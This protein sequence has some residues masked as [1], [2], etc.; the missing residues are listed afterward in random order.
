MNPV[1]LYIILDYIT[2]SHIIKDLPFGQR[3]LNTSDG[4]MIDTPNIIRSMAPQAIIDQ[5]KQYCEELDIEP[6]G[7]FLI[8]DYN[9]CFENW[10]VY[11]DAVSGGLKLGAQPP[12]WRK[13]F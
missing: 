3:K 5:Y 4:K 10:E 11:I 13:H 6:L 8:I 7:K 9:S 1:Q 12:F 2:S